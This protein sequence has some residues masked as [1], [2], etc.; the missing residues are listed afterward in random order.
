MN[1][2]AHVVSAALLTLAGVAA[3]RVGALESVS[4][5]RQAFELRAVGYARTV[6]HRWAAHRAMCTDPSPAARES[7]CVITD[8]RGRIEAIAC[9]REVRALRVTCGPVETSR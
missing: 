4:W 8:G 5:N 3:G 2:L 9:T 1:P 7:L 6:H